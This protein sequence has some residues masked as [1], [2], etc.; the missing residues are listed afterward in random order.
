MAS[1][2]PRASPLG[3]WSAR[4]AAA[5][6]TLERFAIRELP[7][8]TQ[9]NVRGNAQD[10]AFADATARV[11]GG[12]LPLAANTWTAGS[13][14]SAL[15]LGPDEW[16]V[17]AG[18]GRDGSLCDDLRGALEGV[19]SSVTDVSA[20]RTVVE[21]SGAH[22]RSVLAKGC[23][24]DLHISAFAPPQC[25][26]CLL[27]KAQVILQCVKARPVFRLYLRN[28]FADYLARWLTDAAAESSAAA[29]LDT[30]HIASRLGCAPRRGREPEPHL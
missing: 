14:A 7:F 19:H 15:W 29:G 3:A 17:T 30:E 24:L 1:T 16:L 4:F 18:D 13:E 12:A 25:A 5:S 20:H 11:L 2:E 26:Q 23:S 28:S 6:G 10:K 21:L 22:T 27:A 9:I 8:T